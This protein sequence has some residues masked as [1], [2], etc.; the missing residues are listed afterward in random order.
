MSG[1][2]LEPVHLGSDPRSPQMDRFVGSR[3]NAAGAY[4]CRDFAWEDVRRDVEEAL[5][6]QLATLP[7]AAGSGRSWTKYMVASKKLLSY[8]LVVLSRRP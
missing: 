5:D 4:H 1:R 2:G 8:M 3:A 7:P 6:A